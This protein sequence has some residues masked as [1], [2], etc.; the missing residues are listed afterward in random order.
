MLGQPPPR[1]PHPE[2][3]VPLMRGDVLSGIIGL[4]RI[5]SVAM[6]YPAALAWRS[7]KDGPGRHA[8][9]FDS[10]RSCHT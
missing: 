10:S 9:V 2:L 6:I 7:G 4:D 1:G 8:G 5:E 3:L